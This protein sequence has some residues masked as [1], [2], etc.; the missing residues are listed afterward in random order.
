MPKATVFMDLVGYKTGPER[1]DTAY[2]TRGEEIELS[3][4]EYKRLTDLGAVGKAG[5]EPVAAPSARAARTGGEPIV[6]G[7]D[8]TLNPDLDP[9]GMPNDV[10][11]TDDEHGGRFGPE[12]T[13]SAASMSKDELK[14]LAE[15]NNVEVTRS[16]GGAGEPS[17]A[18]Y[19]KALR[20]QGLLD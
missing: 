1:Y 12:M 19:E 8:P 14:A 18:D 16:G 9:G 5:E 11:R 15:A 4:E 2:A 7:E 20:E 3:D 13:R 17:K 10:P 6:I